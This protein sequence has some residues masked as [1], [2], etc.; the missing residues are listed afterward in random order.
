VTGNYSTNSTA[1]N[2]NSNKN[3][4][5]HSLTTAAGTTEMHTSNS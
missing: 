3:L 1:I 5:H 4:N 2:T